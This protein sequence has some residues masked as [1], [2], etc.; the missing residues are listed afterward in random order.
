[1]AFREFIID[2][3]APNTPMQNSSAK[4]ATITAATIANTLR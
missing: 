4:I 3:I 1:M 2:P